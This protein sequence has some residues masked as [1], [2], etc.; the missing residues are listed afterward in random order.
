ML[1]RDLPVIDGIVFT[2]QSVYREQQSGTRYRSIINVRIRDNR[3]I[4]GNV[5]SF[6]TFA[7]ISNS[8]ILCSR[9]G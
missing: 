3:N 5:D 2:G 7:L 9:L 4:R 6:Y 8:G 1:V